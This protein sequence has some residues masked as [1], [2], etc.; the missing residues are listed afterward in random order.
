MFREMRREKQR[1]KHE[2][3][4]AVLERGTSGVL[5]VSGENGYPYAVPLSYVFSEGKLYFHCAMEG[6][7]VDAIRSCDKASFCVVDQDRIVPEKYTTFYRSVIAFGRVKILENEA[8]KR[9]AVDV[10]AQRFR[11]GHDAERWAEIDGAMPRLCVL[12]MTIE[13]MTGKEALEIA[14]SRREAE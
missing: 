4:I 13:H 5:A 3:C 6:H 8:A 7:K 9:A 12:E 2:E 14:N 10:L 11:P 1:M